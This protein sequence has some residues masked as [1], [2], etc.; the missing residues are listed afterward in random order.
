MVTAWPVLIR[1]SC[2]SLKFAVIQ[3]SS[4]GTITSRLC[5]GWT[6]CPISTVF[7]SDHAAH[8]G[9]DFGVTKIELSGVDISARLLQVSGGRFR[10]GASLGHLLW[11]AS[12]GIDLRFPLGH[13]AAHFGNPLL[14]GDNRGAIGLDCLGGSDG[15][16]FAGI[17]IGPRDLA[18]FDQSLIADA[19]PFGAGTEGFVLL[20]FMLSR[21]EVCL[22]GLYACRRLSFGRLRGME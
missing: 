13:Q 21:S 5:P 11:S 18:L 8:R 7:S 9:V 10:F 1:L 22:L 15:F 14:S 17:V 2:V 12:G 16:R 4:T 3:M 6:R 19:V 20:E